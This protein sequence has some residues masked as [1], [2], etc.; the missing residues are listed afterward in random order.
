MWGRLLRP[1]PGSPAP[2]P[3]C[4]ELAG[5]HSP[6]SPWTQLRSVGAPLT[7]VAPTKRCQG[8]ESSL[9]DCLQHSHCPR[10]PIPGWWESTAWQGWAAPACRLQPP[11]SSATEARQGRTGTRPQCVDPAGQ[12]WWWDQPR[13]EQDKLQQHRGTLEQAEPSCIGRSSTAPRQH[14]QLL[15]PP[16]APHTSGQSHT[17]THGR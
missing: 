4:E 1:S 14:P 11:C 9:R 13:A 5:S 6:P 15:L 8:Q 16:M 7:I 3:W 10:V 2:P 17:H 12:Q